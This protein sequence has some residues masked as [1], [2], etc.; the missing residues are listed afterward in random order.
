MSL[1]RRDRGILVRQTADPTIEGARPKAVDARRL[2]LSALGAYLD[3]HGEWSASDVKPYATADP[4]LPSVLAWDHLAP[5]GRDQYVRVVYPGYLFP[6]GHACALVKL[7]ERKVLEREGPQARLYQ[8]KFLVV[9]EPARR[10]GQHDLPFKEVRLRPLATPDIDD[11]LSE[12]EHTVRGF[13][14]ASGAGAAAPP[15]AMAGDELFWPAVGGR[16]FRFELDCLD[17]AGDRARLRAPLLF[18]AAHLGGPD[19]A[20]LIEDMYRADSRVDAGGQRVSVAP[21][22]VPGDTALEVRSF[23][24]G[25]RPGRPG[26][27]SSRP[28]MAAATAFLPA[29]RQLAGGDGEPLVLAYTADYAAKG[30]HADNVG[31][32]FAEVIGEAGRVVYESTAAAGGLVSPNFPIRGLSKTLGPVGDVSSIAAGQFVPEAFLADFTD[33]MPKLLGVVDL[34]SLLDEAAESLDSAPRFISEAL[35][36]PMA[37]IADLPR[38]TAALQAAAKHLAGAPGGAD[39]MIQT[40]L[41]ELEKIRDDVKAAVV[42]V[43]DA[44]ADLQALSADAALNEAATRLTPSLKKIGEQLDRLEAL[45]EEAPLPPTARAEL[46]RLLAALKPF[47]AT[48]E[49]LTKAIESIADMVN[50]LLSGDPSLRARYEWRPQLRDWPPSEDPDDTPILQF[51][52]GATAFA[53]TVEARASARGDAGVDALAELQNLTVNLVPGVLELLSLRFERIAFRGG[54]DRKPEV[55]FLFGGIEFKGILRFVETLSEAIPFDGLSDPPYVDVDASGARAGFDLGLPDL[56]VGVFSLENV[57][58]GVEARVPFLGEAV[59]VGFDFCTRERPFA[60]TVMSFGGGG[61]FGLVASPEELVRLEGALEF[62]ARVSMSFGVASGSIEVM[63][64]VYYRQEGGVSTLS[65]YLRL[66][67]EVVLLGIASVS[68]TAQLSLAYRDKGD[69]KGEMRG[70]AEVTLEVEVL[71]L[72]YSASFTIERSFA[73]AAGDPTLAETIEVDAEGDSE[74]WSEYCLAFAEEE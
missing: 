53:L 32:V 61:Y 27:L 39:T 34:L 50:G 55:D 56:T 51:D 7:T 45:L 70:R 66:R 31:Q 52:D 25:G 14:A 18:V 21:P 6:F 12:D 58:L 72:E 16:K 5:L 28:A 74:E 44:V 59:T 71:F 43:L 3:L 73:G 30:F 2:Y 15:G 42:T 37:L 38:L 13:V 49:D 68:L 29:A 35:D 54:S 36:A 40:Q 69:G 9:G 33:A 41:E 63:G 24:F 10:Y 1:D 64:G 23:A 57:T 26:E 60:L 48:T 4:A 20:P 47:L 11:P 19:E 8:R 62:G 67:G 22:D 46:E 17:Q 65:G